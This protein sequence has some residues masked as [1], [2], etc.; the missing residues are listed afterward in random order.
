MVTRVVLGDSSGVHAGGQ[1]HG[2]PVWR[3]GAALRLAGLGSKSSAGA[4]CA[5]DRH[6]DEGKGGRLI[7]CPFV[8]GRGTVTGY[9]DRRQNTPL[10][11]ADRSETA[12]QVDRGLIIGLGS[13]LGSGLGEG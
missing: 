9:D 4:N 10:E 11:G 7:E 3:N 8:D 13:G 5:A 2:Q 1:E 6:V 12:R